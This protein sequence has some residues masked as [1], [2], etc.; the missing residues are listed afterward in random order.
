MFQ[1]ESNATPETLS[2]VIAW[3]QEGN[4][5][6]VSIFNSKFYNRKYPSIEL[7]SS[8][9]IRLLFFLFQIID[10]MHLT[11]E[12]RQTVS[13]FCN[14]KSFHHLLVEF[15][16]DDVSL[17][18]N[19]RETSQFYKNFDKQMNWT[20]VC[21]EKIKQHAAKYE[22]CQMEAEGPLIKVHSSENPLVHSVTARGVQG[23]LQTSILGKL[24][25]P[26]IKNQLYYFTRHGE[27]D[28]NVLGR[29]GGDA[30]LSSR[31]R[32]YGE[33]LTKYFNTP[34]VIKPKMVSSFLFSFY[35][36]S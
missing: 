20:Y 11:R 1:V 16:C 34:G 29:I 33:R 22:P 28:Y 35:L 31:G 9:K 6:A 7:I 30:D 19:I 5:V 24:S 25:S 23:A 36:R 8:N 14:G 13:N 15:D 12:S 17:E 27:S 3:F 4:N 32:C 18:D 10:G 2:G 21:R 26:V